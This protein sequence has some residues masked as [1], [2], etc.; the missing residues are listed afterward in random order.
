MLSSL[1]NDSLFQKGGGSKLKYLDVSGC[2]SITDKTLIKLASSLE[3]ANSSVFDIEESECNDCHS[4]CVCGQN[5]KNAPT[6]TIKRGL[7]YLALSG[8]YQITDE[9]LRYGKNVASFYIF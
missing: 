6:A 3:K 4:H 1:N 5:S 9:G 2:K 8:C 7:E